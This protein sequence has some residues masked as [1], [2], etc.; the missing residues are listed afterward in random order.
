[1]VAKKKLGGR[2]SKETQQ[3]QVI[4]LWGF[5]GSGKLSAKTD[6]VNLHPQEED[7]PLLQGLPERCA[8]SPTKVS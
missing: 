8:A 3:E 7:G 4:A 1:M 5:L 6:K 2:M